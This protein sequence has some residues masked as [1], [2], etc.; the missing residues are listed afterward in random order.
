MSNIYED[1]NL[2]DFKGDIKI[3]D[4]EIIIQRLNFVR[5]MFITRMANYF[6][7][8]KRFEAEPK[9]GYFSQGKW[10]SYAELVG[11]RIPAVIEAKAIC[12]TYEE[13]LKEIETNGNLDKYTDL[14]QYVP[15]SEE[16]IDGLKLKV[17]E[18]GK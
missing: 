4:N 11:A 10:M 8:K 9:G 13:M 3:T 15:V 7:A 6:D 5:S 16:A 18:E 1:S 14:K 12:D 2:T 17:P